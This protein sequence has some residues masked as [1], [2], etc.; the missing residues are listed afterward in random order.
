MFKGRKIVTLLIALVGAV[1]LWLYVV[2]TVAPESTIRVNNI[3]ISLDGSSAL[4]DHNLIY[5]SN[6]QTLII[7]E[8]DATRVNLELSTSRM[9][10]SKLN[11]ESIRISADVSRIKSPGDYEV[12]CKVVLPDTVRTSSVDILRKSRESINIH[13]SRYE[14]RV[15]ESDEVEIRFPG[16]V[17]DNYIAEI[18][19]ASLSAEDIQ[20]SGPAEELETI[21]K[22]YTVFDLSTDMQG[23]IEEPVT[24]YFE[25]TDGN[26]LTL[27]DNCTVSGTTG[28]L[29]FNIYKEAKVKIYAEL[30]PGGGTTSED[31]DIL[32]YS[33]ETL[34]VKGLPEVIDGMTEGCCVG[35]I[36]LAQID[37][38]KETVTIPIK[39]PDN[40]Y[41]VKEDD[42]NKLATEMKVTIKLKEDRSDY[43]TIDHFKLLNISDGYYA[44]MNSKEAKLIVRGSE[45]DIRALKE[46]KKNGQDPGLTIVVDLAKYDA[47][48]SFSVGADDWTVE[49]KAFPEIG[50]AKGSLDAA[51]S[52]MQSRAPIEPEETTPEPAGS[53]EED[54]EPG[55]SDDG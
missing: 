37:N 43:V 25:D 52:V 1:L 31:Y 16:S 47:T 48:G 35:Q 54:N 45:E 10:V 29:S 24:L 39:L 6:E 21:A 18:G 8:Q 12:E 7:T 30:I 13:V 17:K 51:L 55:G 46:M 36:D 14:T 23:E 28:I 4:D 49:C 5:L 3:P 20:V 53:E 42:A 22:I 38:I 33:P 32:S 50:A 11:A 15:F 40:V 41:A 2:T 34:R 19:S 9:N 27:S 44:A 26:Q